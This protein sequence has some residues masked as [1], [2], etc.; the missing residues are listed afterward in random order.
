MHVLC[1]IYVY[2]FVFLCYGPEA[3]IPNKLAYSRYL[4]A[5]FFLWFTLAT[6]WMINLPERTETALNYLIG[7]DCVGRA[8]LQLLVVNIIDITQIHM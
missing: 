7:P 1:L 4:S 2:M 8:Y 6:I 3:K 5:Q